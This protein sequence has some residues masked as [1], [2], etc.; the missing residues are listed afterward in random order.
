MIRETYEEIANGHEV[1]QNLSKMRQELKDAGER[2]ALLYQLCG[3]F[4][5]FEELF[6][7][8]DPKV[9][10]NVALVA[11]LLGEKA[12]LKPL[13]DAYEKEETLFVRSSYL[14]ALSEFDF[15]EYLPQ[16]KQRQQELSEKELTME[17]KKH[18][19]EEMRV[20]TELILMIEGSKKHK[21][22]GFKKPCEVVLLT[23]RDHKEKLIE[24]LPETM[25]KRTFNAGIIAETEKLRDLSDYRFYEELLFTVPGMKTC[26]MNPEEAA[27]KMAEAGLFEYLQERHEGNH[28]FYFRLEVKSHMPLDKKA[29]FARKFADE[30]ERLTERKMINSTSHY[31][32][33]IRLIENKAG[34]FNVLLKLFTLED[35]R[36]SYR[37]EVIASSIRPVNAALVMELADSYLKEDAKIL[38]PFCGVGTML[39]ERHIHRKANTMYGIDLYGDAIE[40]ARENTE[41]AHQ[42]IHY[43]NRDFFDFRHE[44][45][46]DEIITNMPWQTGK[47]TKED[48]NRLYNRF[49]KKAL[50]HIKKDGHIILYTHNKELVKSCAEKYGYRYEEDWQI[51]QKEGT[52]VCVLTAK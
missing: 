29:V 6:C 46:F 43:I 40:K 49:F 44:Y 34:K 17:N 2:S 10:K 16:L 33:E 28:P 50:E 35:K 27:R 47:T 52:H 25:N 19:T 7:H 24:L 45:L 38:D 31:E 21:F 36:F 15:R 42:I 48:I 32:I 23:N 14:T 39:I 22:T 12:L 9:R 37:Q 30:L 26:P 5:V 41:A 18:I 13:M 20:L 11:G 1:R 51:S 3:D 8:E 4:H